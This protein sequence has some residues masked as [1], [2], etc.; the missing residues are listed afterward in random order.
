MQAAAARFPKVCNAKVPEDAC[1][2]GDSDEEDD[3]D[4]DS[5][6]DE[7]GEECAQDGTDY[8]HDRR[9]VLSVCKTSK[10]C[11]IGAGDLIYFQ[12]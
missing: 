9:L 1:F 10:L 7:E 3:V 8:V 5:E 2:G 6:E 11:W 4:S 12:L